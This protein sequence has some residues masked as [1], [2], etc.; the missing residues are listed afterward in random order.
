MRSF[1][2]DNWAGVH[3]VILDAIINANFEH[4]AAYGDD[5]YTK[6]A[7]D[8][9]RG[10]FG[11]DTSAYF[12][13]TGTAA[14]VLAIES[15]THSFNGVICSEYAHIHV[16]ECGAMEKHTG[17]KLLTIPTENGK[18]T[19][20]Q[21][22]PVVKTERYPHQSEP[23]V[24]SITQVTELG[25]IY[26]LEELKEIADLAHKHGL[27]LHVDGAR[28]SNAA[29]ALKTDFKTMLVDTGVDVV[30]FGGTKNGMMFGEAVVFLKPGL[31]KYFQL[32][33]KQ[34]MQ[35]ASKMRYVAAQFIAL[36]SKN[37]W[38]ENAE[39]ANSMAQYLANKL[40]NIPEIEITQAVE[41][42][43]IWAIIPPDYAE[44][45]R[46]SQFFYPWDERKSEYRIMTGWDT[47]KKEIDQFVA[48]ILS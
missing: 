37:L 3:P 38:K 22:L 46:K 33:R 2:S 34:G 21:I 39:K 23:A 47:T 36:L 6:Y 12:V 9:F 44:K 17:L 45:M 32:Y 24:I 48:S 27:Y 25:T 4:Q 26:S 35:L 1:A 7:Q 14:N 8:L 31:D 15:L 11:A 16:D 43:G 19:P 28:I 13:F 42:N 20:E 5:D 29:A 41:S 30:S 10:I 40:R 18:I